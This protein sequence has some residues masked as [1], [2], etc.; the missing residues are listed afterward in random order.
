[1][2]FE[3]VLLNSIQLTCQL[4]YFYRQANLIEFIKTFLDSDMQHNDERQGFSRGLFWVR[5][6]CLA[7]WNISI[8]KAPRSTSYQTSWYSNREISICNNIRYILSTM[9]KNFMVSLVCLFVF[10]TACWRSSSH[11]QIDS[12]LYTTAWEKSLA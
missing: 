9:T 12:Y 6:C 8:A 2:V 5:S 3:E 11:S 10:L 1:M 7:N 4:T